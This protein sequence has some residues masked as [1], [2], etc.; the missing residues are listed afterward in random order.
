MRKIRDSWKNLTIKNKIRVFTAS[1]FIAILAALLFDVWIIK[2][3]MMDFN[4]I[5]EDNSHSGQLV[6]ALSIEIDTFDAYVHGSDPGDITEWEK[7]IITT[8]KA[9][10][11]N[12]L[13]Y[14]RLGDERYA[15]LSS[16]KS[17]YASYCVS[18]NQVIAQ[19]QS[20]YLDINGLYE[21]YNMQKYL[22]LY[23]QRFD[24]ERKIL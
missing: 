14:R 18:R 2:L 12:P 3:F 22:L 20:G 23:A 7:C 8:Q 9:F 11:K 1:V 6:S 15:L 24:F 16:L 10:D 17:A 21:V 5:M 13:V 19:Y 4:D